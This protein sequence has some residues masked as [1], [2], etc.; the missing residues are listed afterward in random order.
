MWKIFCLQ[1]NL[2]TSYELYT[3][4]VKEFRN[5]DVYWTFIKASQLRLFHDEKLISPIDQA[6]GN[7]AKFTGGFKHI[8]LGLSEWI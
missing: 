8:H 2:V 4:S 1:Y 5:T 6:Y 7:N 3:C